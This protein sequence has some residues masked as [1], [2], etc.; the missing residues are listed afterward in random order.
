MVTPVQ[1]MK[2]C[3]RADTEWE[4][5]L[6]HDTGLAQEQS[7]ESH[8]AVQR[9]N[10]AQLIRRVISYSN[11]LLRV[12]VGFPPPALNAH[13]PTLCSQSD[14]ILDWADLCGELPSHPGCPHALGMVHS[15]D[16]VEQK[17]FSFGWR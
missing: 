9:G 6:S 4:K 1:P 12:M 17:Y 5:L 2:T 10:T 7:W 11:H 8:P 13:Q 15:V 3:V 16:M 14:G